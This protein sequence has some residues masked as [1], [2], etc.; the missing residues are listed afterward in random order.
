MRSLQHFT[1]K[2][3]QNVNKIIHLLFSVFRLVLRLD[4]GSGLGFGVEFRSDLALF[5]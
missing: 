3:H 2:S 4:L 1:V 5:S